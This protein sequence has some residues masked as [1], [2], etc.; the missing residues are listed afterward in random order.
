[1]SSYSLPQTF[2]TRSHRLSAVGLWTVGVVLTIWTGTG[3]NPAEAIPWAVTCG[4][5]AWWVWVLL[6][7]PYVTVTADS[8]VIANPFY[9]VTVASRAISEVSTQYQFAVVVNDR[10]HYA[11][12]LPAP[13][14]LAGAAAGMSPGQHRTGPVTK[15]TGAVQARPGDL[16]G[17]SCG[18]ASEVA[19]SVLDDRQDLDEPTQTTAAVTVTMNWVDIA[20]TVAVTAAGVLL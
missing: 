2:R 13:G 4:A 7:K 1:M 15:A 9:K 14:F 12:A 20:L 19:R 8:V 18:S 10:R 16:T 5:L 11:W 6:W 17:S 3:T